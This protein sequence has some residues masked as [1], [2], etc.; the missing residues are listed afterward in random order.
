MSEPTHLVAVDPGKRHAGVAYFG[1]GLLLAASTVR[2]RRQARLVPEVLRWV[3]LYTTREPS[4]WVVEAQQDYPGKGGRKRGLDSLRRQV[5]RLAAE[6]GAAG[7]VSAWVAPKPAEWK[8]Q[9]PKE[10]H[11]RR[12]VEVLTLGERTRWR[13]T[14]GDLDAR[15]AIGLGLWALGRVGQGGT[16]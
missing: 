16:R 14:V 3:G 15:D 7:L 4:T 11:H 2:V 5:D 8:G 1:H 6:A 10:V 13:H 12:L 9:V